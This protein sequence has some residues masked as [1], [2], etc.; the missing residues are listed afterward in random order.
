MRQ[1]PDYHQPVNN[2]QPPPATSHPLPSSESESCQENNLLTDYES[3]ET[4]PSPQSSAS[5]SNTS[6]SSEPSTLNDLGNILV[7]D[8]GSFDT[9]RQLASHFPP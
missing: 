6:S 9:L 7:E 2:R 1:L 5:A 3:T 8:F 4:L